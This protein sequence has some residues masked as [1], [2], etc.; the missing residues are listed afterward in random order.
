MKRAI[1]TFHGAGG[2]TVSEGLLLPD[3]H[4]IVTAHADLFEDASEAVERLMRAAAPVTFGATSN[5]I[6]VRAEAE[7]V[8][9]AEEPE[10]A[11]EKP[12]SKKS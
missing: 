11:P 1:T 10:P 6:E 2:V 3:D 12:K 7:P 4:E 5:P 9:P 8:A